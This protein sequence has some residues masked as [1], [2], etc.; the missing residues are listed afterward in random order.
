MPGLNSFSPFEI[1]IF[2]FV[3][4]K[5]KSEI[6]AYNLFVLHQSEATSSCGNAIELS[7]FLLATQ[8][9]WLDLYSTSA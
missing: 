8:G 3:I 2:L 1:F 6:F 9:A 5:V 7:E 4:P